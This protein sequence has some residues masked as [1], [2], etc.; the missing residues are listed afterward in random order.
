MKKHVFIFVCLIAILALPLSAQGFREAEAADKVEVKMAVMQGPSGFGVSQLFAKEGEI[1]PKLSV[2][3]SVY[4]SPNEV[5]ARLA[6]KE[7]DVAFLPTNVAANLYAK[8]VKVKI[9]AITGEGMLM[10]LTNDHSITQVT[11]LEQR[12]IYIPGAGST[13]D[14]LTKIIISALGFDWEEDIE[15]DYSI[16]APAQ[17]SQMLIANRV[18]LAVLPEPFVTMTLLSNSNIIPLIDYQDLWNA[19]T[20]V[21]NYPMTVVVVSDDFAQKHPQK[22]V[23]LMDSIKESIAWTVANSEQASYYIEQEGIMKADMAQAA[24]GRSALVFRKAKEGFMTMDVY[25]KVLQGFDY[26]SIGGT[27]PDESFYLD[28]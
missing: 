11:D 24:I 25:L 14:Q 5:I 13:P 4:P 28:Y 7:L 22:L 8:G 26:S 3:I 1:N 21:E 18:E 20:G 19:L 23:E 2:D 16:A 27:L 9:A 15:L 10:L 17:L 6:N 12:E